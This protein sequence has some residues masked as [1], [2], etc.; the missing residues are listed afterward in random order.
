[1][2]LAIGGISR[3][4]ERCSRVRFAPYSSSAPA[5]PKGDAE[6]LLQRAGTAWREADGSYLIELTALPVN[7]R[8]LMRPARPGESP[9]S[10]T[11]ERRS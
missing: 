11:K 7:G 3:Q 6:D 9:D 4:V 5:L 2:I 10:A 1:V 8:L